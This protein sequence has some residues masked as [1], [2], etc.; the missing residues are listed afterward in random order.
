MKSILNKIK[1][2]EKSMVF[3]SGDLMLDEYL[4]CTQTISKGENV[5]ILSENKREFFPGGAANVAQNLA[6]LGSSVYLNGV[7]G[8]DLEGDCLIESLH[9][10][11]NPGLVIRTTKRPTTLKTRIINQD[12]NIV[13]RRDRED[14]NLFPFM[15]LEGINNK[16]SLAVSEANCIVFSDYCKG[17]LNPKWVRMIVN[18]AQKQ[19][20]PIIVDTK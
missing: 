6:A 11:I 3:V 14:V 12:D 5:K 19:Q 4:M 15:E 8:S 9:Q 18:E 1:S 16:M 17:A 2:Q 7:I 10:K 20:K 13:I